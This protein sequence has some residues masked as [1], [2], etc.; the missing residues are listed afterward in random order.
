[1]RETKSIDFLFRCKIPS[2]ETDEREYL[3]SWLNL[4]TPFVSNLPE[5]CKKYHENGAQQC[6]ADSFNRTVIVDCHDNFI[7]EDDEITI[8]NK[9]SAMEGD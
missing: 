6:L 9:V 8:Q 4:S 3:P 1:M 2:C 7:Y 5:K